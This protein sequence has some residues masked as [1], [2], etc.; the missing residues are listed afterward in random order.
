M[1]LGSKTAFVAQQAV[2]P[3]SATERATGDLL[4]HFIAPGIAR[5]TSKLYLVVG[6]CTCLVIGL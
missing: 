2:K 6:L 1:K 5:Y 4:A 3:V